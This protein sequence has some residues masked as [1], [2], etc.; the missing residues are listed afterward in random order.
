MVSPG[1]ASRWM[2]VLAALTLVTACSGGDGED[3]D[4]ASMA[5]VATTLPADGGDAV[6]ELDDTPADTAATDAPLD[7]GSVEGASVVDDTCLA[8]ELCLTIEADEAIGKE[9]RLMLY[10]ADADDWPHGFRDLPTPSWVLEER[11][12]VPERFPLRLRLPLEG[13]LFAISTDPIEGAEVGL[14]IATGVQSI[15][16]VESTDARGF[17]GGTMIYEP[18]AAMDFGTI[19]IALPAGDVCELNPTHPDCLTGELFWADHMLGEPEFVPGAIYLDVADLDGDGVQDIVTVGE[20]HFEDPDRPLSDLKLGVYYLNPDLTVREAE[21]VDAWTEEDPSFYSAWGVR[22]IEHAGDPLIV[23]GT[24]IPGLAPL[25]DGFGNVYSYRRVGD[26]WERDEVMANPD[27]T[28]TNYNA[29]IVVTCD[30]DRDGDEDLAL[31]SAFGS[32]AVGSWMENTGDAGEPWRAHLQTMAADTDPAIRGTLGYTCADL[33][34]DGYPEVVYNAMFD[35]PNTEPARYRGEIWL[36]LNPGP[37]GWDEPWQKVVIDDDNWASADMWFHDFDGDGHPDL[38]ANQIFS[39]TVTRYVHPGDDVTAAWTPEI[40]VDDM[41]SPSDM[42]LADMDGDGLI[43][44]VGA[45]HTAHNGVWYRNPGA[46]EAGMWEG[47]SIFRDIQMPGD[48]SM[49]DV[50]ADGDLDW[51][52]TSM[53]LGQAY[54]VEQVQPEA[55]LVLSISLPD[56][57]D[58]NVTRLVATLAEEVPVTG[59]PV[60]LLTLVDNG[61]ADGDGLN[62][63]DQILS[64]DNDLLLAIDDVGVT[65]DYHVV[66]GLYVEGGGD[67]QPVPGTDWI[68]ESELLTFG[69]GP[70]EVELELD[71]R[72]D[73]CVAGRVRA[74]WNRGRQRRSSPC[75]Q[76]HRRS[77]SASPSPIGSRSRPSS[78]GSS[79]TRTR[80][81]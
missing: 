22:V 7:S 38:I 1:R 27:P 68:A 78:A 55:G 3:A 8:G 56:D 77:T 61:D 10:A 33:T 65:G 35:I 36:G 17:S 14:A 63:V 75:Q 18:S 80:C 25:E 6:E 11:P 74:S 32:S 54:I 69:A 15:M 28:V 37:D 29:M 31:S 2:A 70:V 24:N 44:V 53:T 51:V 16:T 58:A 60:A 12:A 45:D 41:T 21:I 30:L 47:Y 4:V 34:A 52:G 66:V 13:N 40:I 46:G 26:T 5:V 42:W 48:F 49:V 64:P 50:D 76:A 19:E 72:A 23:V 43:D 67:F 57:F 62:D 79:P 59:I 71:S 81:T 73:V 9:L 20:P 39:S